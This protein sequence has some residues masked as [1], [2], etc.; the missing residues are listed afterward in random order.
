MMWK[1]EG[2]CWSS[3]GG[4]VGDIRGCV[5]QGAMLLRVGMLRARYKMAVR[6]REVK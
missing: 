3:K 1:E 5:V 2:R 4:E 6:W